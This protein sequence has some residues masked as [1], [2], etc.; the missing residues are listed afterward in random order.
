[1]LK[2]LL[3][4]HSNTI[5]LVNEDLGFTGNKIVNNNV[6]QQFERKNKLLKISGLSKIGNETN[7][8]GCFWPLVQSHYDFNDLNEVKIAK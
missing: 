3:K 8:A 4:A 7:P 5:S 1:M 6:I 2:L